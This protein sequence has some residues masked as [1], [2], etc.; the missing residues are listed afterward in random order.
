MPNWTKADINKLVEGVPVLNWYDKL[1]LIER[2][3]LRRT[4]YLA[5]GLTAG[6][7]P[8]PEPV[9]VWLVPRYYSD[10]KPLFTTE[11]PEATAH[12]MIAVLGTFIPDGAE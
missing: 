10:G 8:K 4:L 2:G 1:G 6:G 5:A 3:D 9:R 11:L 7:E 12:R